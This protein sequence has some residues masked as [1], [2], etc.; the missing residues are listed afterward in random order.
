ML[1][2][3][4]NEAF[5]LE[6]EFPGFEGRMRGDYQL[7]ATSPA[8]DKGNSDISPGEVTLLPEYLPGMYEPPVFR[9]K[10]GALDI[11][12]YEYQK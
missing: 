8:I 5:N 1:E 9:K 6:T 11:G 2:G 4:G 3:P 12:A 10:Q 7:T